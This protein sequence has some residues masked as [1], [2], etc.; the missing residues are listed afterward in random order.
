MRFILIAALLLS[1][2]GCIFYSRWQESAS[3]AELIKQHAMLTQDFRECLRHNSTNP[4]GQR[5]CSVYNQARHQIDIS[6]FK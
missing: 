6:G 3:N 1:L 2:N 5:D 4:Q